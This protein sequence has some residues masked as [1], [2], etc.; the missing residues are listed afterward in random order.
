MADSKIP[1]STYW[2]G[3]IRRV[4]LGEDGD[5]HEVRLSTSLAISD[6]YGSPSSGV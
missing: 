2:Y 3:E 5:V 1:G 6:Q 4:Y